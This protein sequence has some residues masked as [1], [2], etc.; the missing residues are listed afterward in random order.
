[1]GDV[2]CFSFYP[3]KNLGAYGE[4]GAVVTSNPDLDNKVRML[5]DHGQDKKYYHGRIG[6]NARMDGIQGAILSVKLKHLPAWND[7][8][9]KN[10]GFY[11]DLLKKVGGVTIPQKVAYAKHVYHIYAIR[12]KDRDALIVSL[13]SKDIH[14]GIHYPIPLHLQEAY[15]SL[16]YRKGAF[17]VAETAASEFVSL[18]MYAEL[19]GEQIARVATELKAIVPATVS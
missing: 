5:R 6:W 1:M 2:G 13:A 17:P 16:G 18:P 9:R 4:A 8:R 11:N 12:V 14:C 19:T 15:T 3:G 10:A 7:A